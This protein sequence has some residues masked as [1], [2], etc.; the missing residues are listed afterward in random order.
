MKAKIKFNANFDFKKIEALW[1]L[2]KEFQDV[3]A[4]HKGK[5]GNCNIGE[6]TINT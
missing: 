5:L 2:F 4:W 6:H 3:F 1:L